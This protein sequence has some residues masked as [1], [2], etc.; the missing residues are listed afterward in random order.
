MLRWLVDFLEDF[1]QN[2]SLLEDDNLKAPTLPYV[3]LTSSGP[4]DHCDPF[5]DNSEHLRAFK[6]R[7]HGFLMRKFQP[8]RRAKVATFLWP[9]YK[10]LELLHENEKDELMSF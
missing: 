2:A 1:K 5:P 4:R 3:L 9:D 7:C 6:E 8:S 10:K